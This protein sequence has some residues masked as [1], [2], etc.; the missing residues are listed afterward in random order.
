MHVA[1]AT[2][3]NNHCPDNSPI[4]SGLTAMLKRADAS[5][6]SI[7]DVLQNQ[8]V[9]DPTSLDDE[10]KKIEI[11]WNI[12]LLKEGKIKD[13]VQKLIQVKQNIASALSAITALSTYVGHLL[14]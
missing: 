7:R 10:S 6:I 8:L 3:S 1:Q 4:A 9:K 14:P 5:L 13:M 12:W 2:I 11:K